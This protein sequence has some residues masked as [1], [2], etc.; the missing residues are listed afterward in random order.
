M[1]Q[2]S[3]GSKGSGTNR[4][5]FVPP[6]VEDLDAVLDAYEFIEILGRGGMGAVY[7]ARQITLDRL[8]AIKILPE[9]DDENDEFRFSE[10]FQREA[11]AMARLSHPNII[12]VIDFGQTKDGQLYIVMEYVEGTDLHVL[13]RGG[14]LTTEHIFGWI[15]Q[16]CDAMQYAH[17]QG[18]V[19]RDIKPAN[20]MINTG[21]V[22]KVADFG[23]AKLG[24][25]DSQ[26]TRLTMT[27]VAMGTPDYV[28][29]EV[30]DEGIEP[31][32]R[33]DLYA[34]GVMIYE[35][36]TG[37]IPRGAWR[38]PSKYK[39]DLDPRFDEL[40]VHAMDSDP[41]SRFQHASEISTQLSSIQTTRPP[42]NQIA[43][44]GGG[45]LNL[46]SS[47]TV[48]VTPSGAA[49]S[50][51]AVH[52]GGTNLD[53]PAASQGLPQQQQ[54]KKSKTG[55][56]IGGSIAA[57]LAVAGLAAW[58]M[59]DDPESGNNDLAA[60][61]GTRA[62]VPP[63][64]SSPPTP[65]PDDSQTSTEEPA[66]PDPEP[67]PPSDAMSNP[68]TD[69]SPDPEPKPTPDPPAFVSNSDYAGNPLLPVRRSIH[70]HSGDRP[71]FEV[72]SLKYSR[73]DPWTFELWI[74]APIPENPMAMIAGF[75]GVTMVGHIDN[76]GTKGWHVGYIGVV[77]TP[78]KNDQQQHLAFQ[79]DGEFI[80]I[81]V[82][83]VS[84]GRGPISGI[85]EGALGQPFVIGSGTKGI[86]DE[87][88]FSTVARYK[89]NFVPQRRF[90]ADDATLALWHFDDLSNDVAKDS[91]G[92]G[93][94]IQL[95]NF[96]GWSWDDNFYP[97][98]VQPGYDA[99]EIR[100]RQ[101]AWAEHYRVPVDFEN[102][103]G[104]KFRLVPGGRFQTGNQNNSDTRQNHPLY[105]G[106]HEVTQAE[107]EEIAGEN[108]SNFREG[109][110]DEEAVAGL[111]TRTHP[112]EN[113]NLFDAARFCN[114]LS[115]REGLVAVYRI[116]ASELTAIKTANGYR[117]PTSEEWEYACRGGTTTSFFDGTNSVN[118]TSLERFARAGK[119]TYPVGEKLA[120]VFGLHDIQGNVCE[121]VNGKYASAWTAFEP[122]VR[123]GGFLRNRSVDSWASWMQE[124]APWHH[125]SYDLGFRVVL[126]SLTAV[127]EVP[128]D[129]DI[130]RV[131]PPHPAEEQLTQLE[132]QIRGAF[133]EKVASPYEAALQKLREQ[134]RN[135]LTQRASNAQ[136]QTKAF[137]QTELD[138]FGKGEALPDDDT[139]LPPAIVQLRN[140]WRQQ[141]AK[142]VADREKAVEGFWTEHEGLL[143][144]AT[145]QFEKQELTFFASRSDALSKRLHAEFL[146]QKAVEDASDS[147]TQSANSPPAATPAPPNQKVDWIPLFDSRSLDGWSVTGSARS[148][149]VD[150]D[151]IK[152]SGEPGFLYY[153]GDVFYGAR[154][155]DFDFKAQVKSEGGANSGIFFH[156]AKSGQ[157]F[158][159]QGYEV[160]ICN[161]D[162][163]PEKTGS[164]VGIAKAENAAIPDGEWFD[165]E[166]SVRGRIITTKVNGKEVVLHEQ[167]TDWQPPEDFPGRRIFEGTFALQCHF[168]E[169]GATW[170]RNIAVR[171]YKDPLTLEVEA[172]PGSIERSTPDPSELPK[173][174]LHAFGVDAEGKAFDLQGLDS[175][176]DFVDVVIRPDLWVA[177]RARGFPVSANS[178]WDRYAKQRF[179][180]VALGS[181]GEAGILRQDGSLFPDG[182]PPLV[183][184]PHQPAK[185][186]DVAGGYN[187]ICG[188]GEDGQIYLGIGNHYNSRLAPLGSTDIV[189]IAQW[190]S[191]LWCLRNNGQLVWCGGYVNEASRPPAEI[192]KHRIVDVAVD[193][194]GIALALSDKGQVFLWGQ[195]LSDTL[196][197]APE[198]IRSEVSQIRAGSGGKIAAVRKKNGKWIAWGSDKFGVVSK[199]NGLGPEV[200]EMAFTE[201]Q[202]LW[203]E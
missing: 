31:D 24:D 9:M 196:S 28:A 124:E 147:L 40:V 126:P 193:S 120:N 42:A 119:R 89:G 13:I 174:R 107:Y 192:A 44:R 188:L 58:L 90:D 55:L 71:R 98:V 194:A 15:P 3:S 185:F 26:A 117:L 161:S 190:H 173:G 178:Y 125:V 60:N 50:S 17:T 27:N 164:L 57:C 172:A 32:H 202:L 111:D 7:K 155:R 181:S 22:V 102:S 81:F 62:T 182:K 163:D 10:R 153:T 51:G 133:S 167:P 116:D 138:R 82:D 184:P 131:T 49:D 68:D 38:P 198:S 39:P 123:F 74:S 106:A 189:K 76:D 156:V 121:M 140:T 144:Q 112:V 8:V 115:E 73:D 195:Q 134:F 87:I 114:Q 96:Q 132:K 145:A 93:H 127:S 35:M 19:H 101:A 165:L 139:G 183:W 104:M 29:P 177:L 95:A 23:L 53:G 128:E 6:S 100:Q 20:I 94:D 159:S 37:K 141:N 65:A 52:S 166:I 41:D 80:E 75:D 157:G 158:P 2:S 64:D 72:P 146:G 91:S 97:E 154:F 169:S 103:I 1:S 54:E 175:G 14:Q 152:A 18:I 171:P 46:P 108:T 151:T 149:S 83:G 170:F 187:S 199:I 69:P 113:C 130:K 110:G 4:S 33:A 70:F 78:I 5:D 136:G 79:G 109:G 16:I 168:P 11:R 63:A 56:V 203:I 12:G 47:D 179:A 150:R 88:R 36:L 66:P 77:G 48:P 135:A 186:V 148:F 67:S 85:P 59:H 21:G 143:K 61:S 86:Y 118:Y 142:L 200:V 99:N 137:F 92:N 45:R 201:S 30:L 160:Q 105:F 84:A 129:R 34:V 176:N 43:T 191:T 162:Q 197:P 25:I 180:K 122:V